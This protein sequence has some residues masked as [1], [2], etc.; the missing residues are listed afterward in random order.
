MNTPADDLELTAEEATDSRAVKRAYA[1]LLK[2]HRPDR[3]PDGFSRIH[4]AYQALSQ[5]S[6]A[7]AGNVASPFSGGPA[8]ESITAEDS[9][10]AAPTDSAQRAQTERAALGAGQGDLSRWR[11]SVI[12]A[13]A[14][15]VE[16]LDQLVDAPLLARDL[17]AG[18]EEFAAA[19]LPAWQEQGKQDRILLVAEA[20]L[21][22]STGPLPP[23]APR[24]ELFLARALVWT[25]PAQSN[26]L[27]D[28][29][30]HHDRS[31]VDP[32]FE[33]ERAASVELAMESGE[34][35][36]V[37]RRFLAGDLHPAP[38]TLRQVRKYIH[39]S[40]LGPLRRCLETRL[41]HYN[42][43]HRSDTPI[44][45]RDDPRS[46]SPLP[47]LSEV[48]SD[49]NA[50]GKAGWI[51]VLVLIAIVGFIR[52]LQSDHPQKN[53]RMPAAPPITRPEIELVPHVD[54]RLPLP[55]HIPR[56]GNDLGTHGEFHI[57][58]TVAAALFAA[59][60]IRDPQVSTHFPLVAAA[61]L[62][63]WKSF[64]GDETF[65]LSF[66][67]R[68]LSPQKNEPIMDPEVLM[69]FSFQDPRQHAATVFEKLSITVTP[70]QRQRILDVLATYR[71]KHA[72]AELKINP[73]V[74]PHVEPGE[75]SPVE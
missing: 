69:A 39:S 45:Q 43:A 31:A 64:S 71:V 8:A 14:G 2:I 54:Q 35:Q 67:Q 41:I 70:E 61:Q 66:Y 44:G 30:F 15:H 17:L 72:E 62:E 10:P 73:Q 68:L 32:H 48:L 38:E 51:W 52:G 60:V 6:T 50:K 11:A 22:A 13:A 63:K 36:E 7:S 12:E 3:D 49:S 37:I 56:L 16:A 53:Q 20:W 55:P 9:A 57:P 46:N 18:H 24:V 26:E 59:M 1:R 4:A 65:W 19:L 5:G 75:G 40:Q 74:V 42:A 28:L 25:H 33:T 27:A 58:S 47:N 29:A 21:T 23:F 34:L